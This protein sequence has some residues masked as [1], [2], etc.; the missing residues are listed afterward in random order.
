MPAPPVHQHKGIE[1]SDSKDSRGGQDR[2][3]INVKQDHE[4]RD[5]SKKF[6]VSPDQ[7]QQAV[8]AVGDRAEAVEKYLKS[9]KSSDRAW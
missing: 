9:S 5:W 4:L 6:G 8:K 3:R 1:M 7:L 2:V